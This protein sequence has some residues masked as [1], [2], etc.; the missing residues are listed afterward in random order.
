MNLNDTSFQETANLFKSES[1]K[2]E[3]EI[4]STLEKSE[5]L[6]IPEIVQVYYQIINVTSLAQLLKQH[7][8]DTSV[9]EKQKSVFT[10]LEKVNQLISDKF[11]TKLHPL[12]MSQLTNSIVDSINNLKSTKK[13][14]DQ[15]SKETIESEAKLY[16]KL[17][18][19]MSTKEFVEQYD[20]GLNHD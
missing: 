6:S 1:E 9:S 2:L 13:E 5:K 3:T 11:N 20:K 18:E 8:E 17:R 10:R 7:L 14:I 15:K 16:E 4:Y 19:T 12:V